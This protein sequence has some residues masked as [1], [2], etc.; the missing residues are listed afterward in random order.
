MVRATSKISIERTKERALCYE[1]FHTLHCHYCDWYYRTCCGCVVPGAGSWLS[2][3]ARYCGHRG[4]CDLAHY[5][6]CRDDGDAQQ[7]PPVIVVK[8]DA[9]WSLK[10]IEHTLT[11]PPGPG[12]L[13]CEPIY[14]CR[15]KEG[16]SI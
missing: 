7:K 4:R 9:Y 14:I 2:S 8:K 16:A 13:T 11:L 12:I 5:W 3:Y 6:Y 15:L 1:K 10:Q